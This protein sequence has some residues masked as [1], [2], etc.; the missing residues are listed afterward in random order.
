[1]SAPRFAELDAVMRDLAKA[2]SGASARTDDLKNL[3]R[4]VMRMPGFHGIREQQEKLLEIGRETW[5]RTHAAGASFQQPPARSGN[6][7]SPDSRP[8]NGRITRK[9]AGWPIHTSRP[10]PTFTPTQETPFTNDRFHWHRRSGVDPFAMQTF[11]VAGSNRLAHNPARSGKNAGELT[12]TLHVTWA[13]RR[14][15]QRLP[16]R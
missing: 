14:V 5:G 7:A 3:V 12:V 6:S 16:L 1:M 9:P 13:S 15:C 2:T 8:W 10:E 11:G 4:A